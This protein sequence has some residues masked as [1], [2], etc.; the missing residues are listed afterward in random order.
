MGWIGADFAPYTKELVYDGDNNFKDVYEAVST[1][2]DYE[3]WK[4]EIR[5]LRSKSKVLQFIIATA[6]ASPLIKPLGLNA[7]IVHLWGGTGVG[8]TVALMVAM[9][10]W[11]NP[12]MG[13]LTRTLNAT[14]VALARYA[15]FVSSIPFAGD[16]LQTIKNRWDSFDNLVMYLTERN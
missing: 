15:S 4:R 3:E 16:E 13:K 11:G 2:G 1:K 7:Y 12:A 5:I 8:K 6:F 10:V 9:S 14:Q